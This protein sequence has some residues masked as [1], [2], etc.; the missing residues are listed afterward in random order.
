MHARKLLPVLTESEVRVDIV[1]RVHP[2]NGST[3]EVPDLALVR[4]RAAREILTQYQHSN[5][6]R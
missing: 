2:L 1:L 4:G 3:V 6:I 5:P